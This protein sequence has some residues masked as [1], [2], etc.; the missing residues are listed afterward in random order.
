MD[1]CEKVEHQASQ[2]HSIYIEKKEEKNHTCTTSC[3]ELTEVTDGV[4]GGEG[5]L[6]EAGAEREE[7]NVRDGVVP[8]LA[9]PHDGR[10]GARVHADHH[11]PGVP[12]DLLHGFEEAG[13]DRGQPDEEVGESDG[14]EGGAN[15]V[16]EQGLPA[17]QQVGSVRATRRRRRR[18]RGSARHREFATL[19]VRWWGWRP[20]WGRGHRRGGADSF[21]GRNGR[22]WGARASK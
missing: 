17:E 18:R 7:S 12:H 3:C 21:P 20:S 16:G 6:R 19:D 4:D 11:L 22:E 10:P 9:A 14:V 15:A 8:H 2:L 13:R 1:G 5:D